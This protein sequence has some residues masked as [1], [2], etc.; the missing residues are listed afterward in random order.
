MS[1]QRPEVVVG[2]DG[3]PDAEAALQWAGNWARAQHARL[4]IVGVWEWPSFQGV[5]VMFGSFDPRQQCKEQVEAAAA[6]ID[7]ADADVRTAVVKGPPAEALIEQSRDAALLVVGRRGI[8][9]FEALLLGSVSQKCA[10][11]AFC[12]V[13]V[14]RS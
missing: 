14:V 5:P 4:T 6:T 3:S 9:G 1:G 7:L 12:P 8:G 2:Y 10:L 11:H 13:A